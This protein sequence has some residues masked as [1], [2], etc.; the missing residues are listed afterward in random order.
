[1]GS[2]PFRHIASH[3]GT[4]TTA[5]QRH[6]RD[7][8]PA[9]L[10]KSQQAE[11]MARSTAL[12]H[13]AHRQNQ[14]DITQADS[15]LDRLLALSQ[16]TLAI[17]QEAREG[18]IKDNMLALKAIARSEKQ[19]ELQAR[20]LG[21]LQDVSSVNVVISPEWQGLRATILQALRP[22]PEARSAVAKALTYDIPS[23]NDINL[24]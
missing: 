3:F 14:R 12:A 8:I 21:E 7:H 6:K 18:S 2:E 20:I 11:E 17:L 4:S 23:P 16:E 15:L 22:Y 13:Q 5:L 10:A 24:G 9:L 1:M 19:L